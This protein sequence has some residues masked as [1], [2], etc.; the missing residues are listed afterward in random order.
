MQVQGGDT[1][2]HVLNRRSRQLREK[3]SRL[4]IKL[5]VT[6]KWD[7]QKSSEIEGNEYSHPMCKIC[8]ITGNQFWY[9]QCCTCIEK[10]WNVYPTPST[11]HEPDCAWSINPPHWCP[12][13]FCVTPDYWHEGA[14]ML[15]SP[16]SSPHPNGHLVKTVH[17]DFNQWNVSEKFIPEAEAAIQAWHDHMSKTARDIVSK[18]TFDALGV[19]SAKFI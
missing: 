16:E 17:R 1:V 10:S 13:R 11:V 6:C 5:P 2:L 3:Y 4:K 7:A 14:M 9:C 12:D 19:L 15:L 18:H 8:L